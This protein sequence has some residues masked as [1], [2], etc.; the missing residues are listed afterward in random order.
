MDEEGD[1]GMYALF[2]GEATPSNRVQALLVCCLEIALGVAGKVCDL[3]VLVEL[4]A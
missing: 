1:L 3:V 2:T 4:G